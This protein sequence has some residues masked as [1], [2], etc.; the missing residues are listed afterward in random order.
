MELGN[1]RH[2]WIR[3][4]ALVSLMALVAVEALAQAGAVRGKVVDDEG[5]PLEGV[6]ILVDYLDGL[7]RQAKT[8]TNASGDFVQVGLRTGNYSVTFRHKGYQSGSI[9]IRIRLGE[10][11]NM[12]DVTMHKLPE[13]MLSRE[14]AEALSAEIQELFTQGVAAVESEDY[15]GALASFDK[16]IELVPTSAEAHFNKGFIYMKLDDPEKALPCYE[17]A[18]ELQ[19]DYYD[20]LVELGN[21][22]NNAHRWA[23]AMEV[24]G[25]AIEIKSTDI[26]TLYNYGAVAMNAVEMAKAQEAFGKV[27]EL[28]PNHAAANYQMGMVMVNQANNE[29]AIPYLE[30]YLEL[31]PEGPHA[32]AAK[33]VLDYLK[34]D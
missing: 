5:Q 21:I 7:T 20:A 16:V 17:K 14:E 8:T 12:G 11:Y 28:D 6:E 23:E 24:F 30:K 15:Q 34:K 19:P 1:R 2:P 9:E 25:R 18:V 26:S 4:A 32:A 33:G 10:P 22:H 3:T 27:L 29:A 13:G 31:D